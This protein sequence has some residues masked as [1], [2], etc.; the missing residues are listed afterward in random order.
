MNSSVSEID[1]IVADYL[2]AV[3]TGDKADLDTL[4]DRH[5]EHADG[6]RDY[7]AVRA[8]V[9]QFIGNEDAVAAIEIEGYDILRE[10]G[11][12][13]MGVVFEAIQKNLHRQ[14]A[15]KVLKEGALGSAATKKRFEDEAKLIAQ[16]DHEHIVGVIDYGVVNGQPYMVMPLVH[17][18][19]LNKVIQKG[20]LP[21]SDV[22]RLMLQATGAISEAHEQGIVHRDIKPANIL[23][24]ADLKSCRIADFGLAAWNEQTQRLTQTGDIIGTAGYIAPEIIRGKS[25]GD[26]QSD[27]YSIGATIYALLTGVPPFR[28]TTPAES[29]LLAMNSDPVAPRSMNSGIP[30]DIES[31]CLKCM[32]PSSDRRYAT[33]VDVHEDL[34]RFIDGRLVLARPVSSWESLS[35][36]AKRNQR[37]AAALATAGIL[38]IGLLAAI[39]VSLAGSYR[40]ANELDNKN[41][42][43][44]DVNRSLELARDQET[45][46]KLRAQEQRDLAEQV[47]VYIA[48]VFK[49]PSPGEEGKDFRV[50]DAIDNALGQLDVDYPDDSEFKCEMLMILG[51]NYQYLS[52]FETADAIFSRANRTALRL[53]GDR[54]DLVDS[55]RL[56]L[57]YNRIQENGD[58]V[59]SASEDL[60]KI[61]SLLD[62]DDPIYR[63][64]CANLALAHHHLK[65]FESEWK[66]SRLA[67]ADLDFDVDENK[68]FLLTQLMSMHS[69]NPVDA[70]KL[71]LQY[72]DQFENE[73]VK[74]IYRV[75]FNLNFGT[76]LRQ[77]HDYQRAAKVLQRSVDEGKQE[78]GPGN[79]HVTNASVGL[80]DSLIQLNQINEAVPILEDV[81]ETSLDKF[82]EQNAVT[83]STMSR[84]ADAYVRLGKTEK[85]I[86]LATR[87]IKVAE[88]MGDT[89][90]E[91]YFRLLSALSSS[92]NEAGRVQESLLILEEI[93]EYCS[94]N[95]EPDANGINKM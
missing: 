65:D 13:A 6:I 91:D 22:A 77:T 23:A 60:E 41:S 50:V 56:R 2:I 58:K 30:V 78:L 38:L 81:F 55:T 25:K 4:C 48:N 86:P 93:D 24:D 21:H 70:E 39:S 95:Y 90:S 14:V 69:H 88:A 36:W 47:R 94:E 59:E 32:H 28:A 31:I 62:P 49:S 3:E 85:A 89:S 42:E 66:Y 46:A 29:I 18:K 7:F 17:G 9:L 68:G 40:Y 34:K 74:P 92:L 52:D 11:R 80:G 43:L 53:S 64:V 27:I 76:L 73:A 45:S 1:K 37:L 67:V 84:L 15:I 82:G 72:Q 63:E 8:N 83:W 61:A 54:K 79:I 5:P 44:R 87:F 71:Y 26:V 35:R 19:A 12:G 57:A 10:I 51:D 16:L 20:P 75:L 33:V